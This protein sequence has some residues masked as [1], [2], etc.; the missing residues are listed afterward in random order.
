[1]QLAG[2]DYSYEMQPAELD[3]HSSCDHVPHEGRLASPLD[4]PPSL[5]LGPRVEH[6]KIV[7]D[8]SIIERLAEALSLSPVGVS[9]HS[10]NDNTL[11]CHQDNNN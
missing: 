2:A 8:G 11:V 6:V 4:I 3:T 7:K 10:C 1:M 9:T 5:R